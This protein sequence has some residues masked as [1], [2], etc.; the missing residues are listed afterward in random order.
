MN[1]EL[2]LWPTYAFLPNVIINSLAILKVNLTYKII[3][4][5]AEYKKYI[6]N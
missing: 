3:L 2:F 4:I 1:Y 6:S 5:K